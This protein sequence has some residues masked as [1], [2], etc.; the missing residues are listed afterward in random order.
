LRVIAMVY[1]V[2]ATALGAS[3]MRQMDVAIDD[4]S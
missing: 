4:T 3:A 1:Y 2:A